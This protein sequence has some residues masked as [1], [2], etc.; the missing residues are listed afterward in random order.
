MCMV[1]WIHIDTWIG[2]SI[3]VNRSWHRTTDTQAARDEHARLVREQEARFN[4]STGESAY[5]VKVYGDGTDYFK[6]WSWQV[7]FSLWLRP[8]TKMHHDW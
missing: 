8:T 5:S 2:I 1:V 3:A 4:G 6:G 7:Y